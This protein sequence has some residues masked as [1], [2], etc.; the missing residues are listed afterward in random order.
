MTG[1]GSGARLASPPVR[2]A[3]G[4]VAVIA[5][6]VAGNAVYAQDYLPAV[7]AGVGMLAALGALFLGRTTPGAGPR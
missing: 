4:V 1:S 2:R 3:L 7:I 6:L 5:G